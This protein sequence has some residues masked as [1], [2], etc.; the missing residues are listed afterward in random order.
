[1]QWVHTE[2]DA[3]L[4]RNS[5]RRLHGKRVLVKRNW[6]WRQGHSSKRSVH[7][8]SIWVPPTHQA[9]RRRGRT[10]HSLQGRVCLAG[11][12]AHV[13]LPRKQALGM[14]NRTLF[15]QKHCRERK[16]YGFCSFLSC[17]WSCILGGGWVGYRSSTVTQCLE[18]T[19]STKKSLSI[20]SESN[21]TLQC[22]GHAKAE[23]PGQASCI[24][25]F[26]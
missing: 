7:S 11:R 10:R 22:L 19:V 9:Q 24:K 14:L 17:M 21:M 26:E 20:S 18:S 15:P 5:W 13:D 8:R 6:K 3:G 1:M 16:T 23:S 12:S 25:S 2:G 4:R